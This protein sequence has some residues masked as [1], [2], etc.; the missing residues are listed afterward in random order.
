MLESGVTPLKQV[1][2][3]QQQQQWTRI[4]PS[5]PREYCTQM[6]NTE[7]FE[8]QLCVWWKESEFRY[9]F[10]SGDLNFIKKN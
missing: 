5:A 2:E 10:D 8:D 4:F 7:F 3:Q 6:V 9:N 1:A